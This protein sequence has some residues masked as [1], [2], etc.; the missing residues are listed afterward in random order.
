MLLGFGKTKIAKQVLARR[1]QLVE[2][3]LKSDRH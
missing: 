3:H 1:G 2:L